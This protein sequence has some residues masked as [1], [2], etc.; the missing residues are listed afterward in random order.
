MVQS[1][2]WLT[3]DFG[4]G[5]DLGVQRLI[6]AS[7]SVPHRSLLK[8]LSLPLPLPL[9][10]LSLSN[11]YINKS[12]LIKKKNKT[13]LM[14]KVPEETTMSAKPGKERVTRSHNMF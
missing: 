14:V 13:F 12:F 1:V 10:L 5:P 11:T 3:V 8:I 6:P 9:P 2:K 7:G 4:S